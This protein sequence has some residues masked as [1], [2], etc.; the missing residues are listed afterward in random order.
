M[1]EIVEAQGF[2]R[3]VDWPALT[4]TF[5]A[6]VAEAVREEPGEACPGVRPLLEALA[7]RDDV[8]LAL[9]TGNFERGARA[10][11]AAHGLDRY[12]ATGGF[13]D[14]AIARDTILRAGIRRAEALRGRAFDRVVVIGDTPHDARAA[15]QVGAWSLCVATGPFPV[16]ALAAA[17]ATLVRRALA[18][19]GEVIDALDALPACPTAGS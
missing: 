14:D 18:P 19:A 12:F 11:L 17:G 16:D 10:K 7:R 8:T 6:Y 1:R 13:G 15:A 2:D 9:G 5:L 4:A 3:A